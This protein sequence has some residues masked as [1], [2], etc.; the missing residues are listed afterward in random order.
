MKYSCRQIVYLF[1]LYGILFA[2]SKPLP[3]GT[4]VYD[5]T[6]HGDKNNGVMN[7]PSLPRGSCEQCHTSL[8]NRSF[9]SKYFLWMNNDNQL[10]FTCHS[11]KS[12]RGSYPGQ[13]IY[14]NSNHNTDSQM[15]WPGPTPLRRMELDAAG[16]CLNCHDPHGYTDYTGLI[17]GLTIAREENLCLNCHDGSPAIKNVANDFMKPYAHPVKTNINRHSKD[18]DGNPDKYAYYPKDNRHAECSDCHNAHVVLGDAL[19]PIHPNASNRNKMVSGVRVF[20][21]S[22]GTIPTYRYRSADEETPTLAEYEICFKCHSSWNRQPPGQTDM[23]KVFNPNNPSYHPVEV[24]GKNPNIAIGAFVN[25]WTATKLIFCSDCHGSD[26]PANKG[27]HGSQYK[28]ILKLSY[29]PTTSFQTMFITELCFDCHN[30]DTYANNSA[31]DTAKGYSRWNKIA[32][33]PSS[34]EGHT[35]HVGR[36]LVTCYSCHDSHGSVNNPFLIITGRTPGIVTY[37]ATTNGGT[38][39]NSITCHSVEPK[40]YVINYTR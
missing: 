31:S 29:Q 33:N 3:A 23:G 40:S 24:A 30:Y 13:L 5:S 37:S 25:N 8:D 32:S 38:C 22:A 26:N 34:G 11:Q 21:G 2:W 15:I 39:S 19:L 12:N 16:K 17:P 20:N 36:A 18:E 9:Q 35:V 6:A 1:I 7:N 27:P 10:C 4:G 28:N 14:Q